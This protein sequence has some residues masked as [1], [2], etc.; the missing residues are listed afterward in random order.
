MQPRTNDLYYMT[1]TELTGEGNRKA[2]RIVAFASKATWP[3]AYAR[4]ADPT[5]FIKIEQTDPF[6]ITNKAAVEVML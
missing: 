2:S 4:H 6:W 1:L 5:R 3:A